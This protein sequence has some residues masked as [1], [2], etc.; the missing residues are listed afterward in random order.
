MPETTT[1]TSHARRRS[2]GSTLKYSPSPPMMPAHTLL[3]LLRRSFFTPL[4]VLVEFFIIY[5][6][7]QKMWLL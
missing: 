1:N 4:E 5:E 3:V 2:A 6:V 7:Y